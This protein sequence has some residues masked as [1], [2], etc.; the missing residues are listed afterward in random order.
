MLYSQMVFL[1]SWGNSVLKPQRNCMDQRQMISFDSW[2]S[3]VVPKGNRMSTKIFLGTQQVPH[4]IYLVVVL[5][6]YSQIILQILYVS[7]K[8]IGSCLKSLYLLDGGPPFPQEAI[9]GPSHSGKCSSST[10]SFLFNAIASKGPQLYRLSGLLSA[11]FQPWIWD[12][13]S[14]NYAC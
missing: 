9:T 10:Q 14:T 13:D 12:L 6:K 3:H 8:I 4:P 5:Q 1:T 11:G 7:P 2:V